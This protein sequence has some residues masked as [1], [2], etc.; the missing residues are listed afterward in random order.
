M[1]DLSKGKRPKIN[2][3]VSKPYKDLIQKCWSQNPTDRPT[4][5]D[6]VKM[7]R[8][9]S[10]FMTDSTDRQECENYIEYIDEY[11]IIYEKTGK[12]LSFEDFVPSRLKRFAPASYASEDQIIKNEKTVTKVS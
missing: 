5:A 8:N 7:L 2:G 4:F 11:Q 6:I 10:L 12:C 9:D 3:P 1:K